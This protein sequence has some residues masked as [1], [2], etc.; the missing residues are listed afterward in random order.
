M[1]THAQLGVKMPDNKIVGCYVHYDGSTM[2]QRIEDYLYKHTTTDLTVLI[3]QAQAR[4]GMRGFNYPAVN[5]NGDISTFGE[6]QPTEFLDD[7]ESYVIDETNWEEDHFGAR[8]RYLVD[9]KTGKIQ[10]RTGR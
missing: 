9:Y 3:A 4:G 10:K 6:S 7:N 2:R 5:E 8:Y 1:G